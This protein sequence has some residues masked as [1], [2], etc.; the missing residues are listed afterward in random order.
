MCVYIYI[1]IYIY[2]YN[3]VVPSITLNYKLKAF[4]TDYNNKTVEHICY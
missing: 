2:I 3:A 4:L 1:Y